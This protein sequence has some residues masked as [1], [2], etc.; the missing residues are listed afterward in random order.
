MR[1]RSDAE[2]K[3][4]HNILQAFRTHTR[5]AWVGGTLGKS[6][7]EYPQEFAIEFLTVQ[8]TGPAESFVP[9]ENIPRFKTCVCDSVTTNYSPQNM[10]TAH[11]RGA[12]VAITLGLHFQETELVMAQDVHDD[13]Y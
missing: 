12:P 9:N 11:K 8:G 2:M 3:E 7:M 13:Y 5:P 6:F 1:P 4:I 10:W